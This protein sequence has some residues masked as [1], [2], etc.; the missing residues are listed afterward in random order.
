M[1]PSLAR[2]LVRANNHQWDLPDEILDTIDELIGIDDPCDELRKL[3]ELRK[4]LCSEEV[5]RAACRVQ[6]SL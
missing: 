2:L 4:D 6:Q 5:Y 3:C 1:L